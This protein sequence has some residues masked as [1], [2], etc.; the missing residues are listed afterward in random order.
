MPDDKS[1]KSDLRKM[2]TAIV[3]LNWNG[4]AMLRRYLPSVVA[5]CEG[6]DAE[7]VVADNAS[8]DGSMAMLAADFPALRTIA[9]DSNYGFAEGYNRALAQV[10]AEYYVL[11]NSDVS[12]P[13]GWLRPLTSFMDA[14]PDVAACQPKLLAEADHSMFE[15]AGAAGGFIDRYGYP[16]CRGRLFSTVE[17][18]CGQYD[19]V[20][21]IHWATGA[22]LLVRSSDWHSVGGLDPR[23]FAHSEEIDFCWR[24]RKAGRRICCVPQS[25]VYHVGGGTL[26]KTNSRKTFLNFRNNL[27]MLYKCLPAARLSAV[28]R[29]R[30]WLDMLAAMQMA[31]T[32]HKADASAVVEARRAFKTWKHDFDGDRDKLA[33][34]DA[35]L[36][37]ICLLWQYYVRGRKKYSRLSY[38]NPSNTR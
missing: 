25:K 16:Y 4:E 37:G 14:H 27:T 22:A 12:T 9:L 23:F 24:L 8:T 2:K 35:P 13:A 7:V 33:A 3:I 31:L 26:P 1:D 38:D 17:K 29:A 19:T 18:D 34:A 36:S 15:Y 32:G 30:F 5:A 21:D 11:L 20:A 10:E 28:M 6:E